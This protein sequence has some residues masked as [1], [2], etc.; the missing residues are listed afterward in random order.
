MAVALH[1][2]AIIVSSRASVTFYEKLGFSVTETIKRERDEIVFMQGAGTV[3]E[4][5]VDPT[6]PARL[7]NPEA[8]GLRHIALQFDDIETEVQTLRAKGYD[9]EPVRT[10][11]HGKKFTFVKDPD[12]QPVELHE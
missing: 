8:N 5:F 2:I 4:V 1:H 9:V 7:S 11:W 10:D 3:L 12:G 6:H